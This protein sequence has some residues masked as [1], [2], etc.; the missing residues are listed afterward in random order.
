MPAS[1]AQPAWKNFAVIVAEDIKNLSLLS[2]FADKELDLLCELL[3]ERSLDAGDILF[4]EGSAADGLYW[5]A[6]GQL[7]SS[8][9][10]LGAVG[11]ITVGD[12][13]GVLSLIALGKREVTVVADGPCRLFFLDR[14]GYHRLIEDAPRAVC[15]LHEAFLKDFGQAVRESM[16]HVANLVDRNSSAD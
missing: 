8:Q 7:R 2:D 11:S 6:D 3:Q 9:T 14:H 5:L 1:V 4:Q 13:F 16:T 12:A 10:Q 15:R